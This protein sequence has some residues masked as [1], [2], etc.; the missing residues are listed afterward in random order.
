[1]PRKPD[2][3]VNLRLLMNS[4]TEEQWEQLARNLK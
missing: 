3:A 4:L 2:Y 1:M